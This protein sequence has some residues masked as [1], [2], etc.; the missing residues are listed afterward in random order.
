MNRPSQIC[1]GNRDVKDLQRINQTRYGL[2]KD[3]RSQEGD[4]D[5]EKA[6]EPAG[7]VDLRGFVVCPVNTLDSSQKNNHTGADEP[8]IG[9]DY[10]PDSSGRIIQPLKVRHSQAAQNNINQTV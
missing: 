9:D 7:A 5:I 10:Y 1:Q 2:K 3:D 6:S 4:R 8:E